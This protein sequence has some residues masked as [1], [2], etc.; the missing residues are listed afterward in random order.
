MKL[1]ES[2]SCCVRESQL[3]FFLN[4]TRRKKEKRDAFEQSNGTQIISCRAFC[5]VQNFKVFIM[6]SVGI[7]NTPSSKHFIDPTYI[8]VERN[9]I[10]IIF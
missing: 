4:K 9:F 2:I 1:Q 7:G 8:F 6:N 3:F 10:L 5:R